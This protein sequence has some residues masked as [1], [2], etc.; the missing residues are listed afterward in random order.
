MFSLNHEIVNRLLN[1]A[2]AEVSSI[3]EL[4]NNRAIQELCGLWLQNHTLEWTS[5]I[6][7]RKD[8]YFSYSL[9]EVGSMECFGIVSYINGKFAATRNKEGSVRHN[10]N[11]ESDARKWLEN[12]AIENGYVIKK[13]VDPAKL[14]EEFIK[15][16]V[17]KVNYSMV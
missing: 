11:N 7:D 1:K 16:F 6:F 10:F 8:T 13:S 4:E 9:I 12:E 17:N 2:K 3:E 5:K 15:D 14:S